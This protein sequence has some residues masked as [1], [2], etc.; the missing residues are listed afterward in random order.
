MRYNLSAAALVGPQNPAMATN[1][2]SIVGYALIALVIAAV[3]LSYFW[4]YSGDFFWGPSRGL[5]EAH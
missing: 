1:Q 5:P 3:I 2:D 4:P